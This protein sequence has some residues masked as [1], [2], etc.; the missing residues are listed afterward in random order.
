M[1]HGNGT[2]AWAPRGASGSERI[3]IRSRALT[4]AVKPPG[5]SNGLRG[6]RVLGLAVLLGGLA[7]VWWGLR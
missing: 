5:V 2:A 4:D 3:A 6:R 1:S 7:L